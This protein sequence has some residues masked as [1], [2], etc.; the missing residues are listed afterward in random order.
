MYTKED[1]LNGQVLLIDKPLTWSSFQAVNKLKYVLKNR[2]DLP[3]KFKIGHAG[4]LDPL[5]TGLLIVCTGKYTK[6]IPELM[7]QTKEYTGT[8]KLGATTPSYDLETPINAI[9]PIEHIT[10]LLITETVKQFI[11][12]IDQKPPVFS[13]LKKDGKR[14]YEHAR[15]GEEI[16]IQAR[17]TTIY[18]FEITRI[19]LPE[20]DFRISCSKGTYIRSLAYDLGKALES[21]GHLT[22]LRRTKSGSYSIEEAL[23][24]DVFSELIPNN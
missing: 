24:P 5:A 7:G 4:T 3:K 17:K 12:E 1:I 18:E 22:A 16:E 9:F 8:I 2:L 15:A 21:G 23:T 20:I 6:K 19:A 14:L 11:G 13:A 10:P